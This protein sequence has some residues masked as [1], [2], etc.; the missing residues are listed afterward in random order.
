MFRVMLVF[1]ISAMSSSNVWCQPK[2][3]AVLN[4]ASFQSG[5]PGAGALATAYVSGLTALVPGTYLAPPHGLFL[6]LSAESR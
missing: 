1:V 6:T 3:V 2:V 4:A 5:I